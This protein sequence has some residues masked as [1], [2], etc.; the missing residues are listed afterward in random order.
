MCTSGKESVMS[1]CVN[2]GV[3]LD[4]SLRKCP[5]CNTPVL[6]PREISSGNEKPFGESSPFPKEKE[7]VEMVR[8]KDEAILLTT[9]VLATSL[10]CGLLNIM[11]FNKVP[12]SLAVIG[13]C[14]LIWV[15]LIP[16]T[17]HTRQTIYT[18]IALDGLAAAIYLYMLTFLTG[19]SGWFFELGIYIVI[20]VILLTEVF[21]LCRNKISRSFL[22]TALYAFTGVALLCTGLE[23]LIDRYLPGEVDI[24]WS[25]IV[26]TVCIIVDVTIITLLSRKRLRGEIRKRLHF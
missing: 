21:V 2:C 10:V 26:V 15:I 13:F 8:R 17:I 4:K 20:L 11:V 3:E 23:Y 1:Y 16:V 5:L 14:V 12:W 6:N 9:F 18:S 19:S 22:A 7:P 25:A 24:R